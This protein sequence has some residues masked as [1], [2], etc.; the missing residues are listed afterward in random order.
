MEDRQRGRA[1]EW[2]MLVGYLTLASIYW[3]FPQSKNEA[4]KKHER[5]YI[6][7]ELKLIWCCIHCCPKTFHKTIPEKLM[8]SDVFRAVSFLF[9]F[10]QRLYGSFWGKKNSIQHEKKRIKKTATTTPAR[11]TN[12]YSG[13]YRIDGEIIGNGKYFALFHCV[14]KRVCYTPLGYLTALYASILLC[15]MDQWVSID[16]ESF[17]SIIDIIFRYYCCWWRRWWWRWY[18]F[19][20]YEFAYIY[21]YILYTFSFIRIC[22]Y[23]VD[24]CLLWWHMHSP[25][26][27]KLMF[28]YA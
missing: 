27:L 2:G 26:C 14:C 28:N 22:I 18:R 1:S 7:M 16:S 17:S 4:K 5:I 13:G 8:F 25:T 6:E 3:T 11:A 19:C 9:T 12:Q 21:I 10:S 15:S 23:C 24:V 20:F